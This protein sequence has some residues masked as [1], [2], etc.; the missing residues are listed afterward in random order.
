MPIA[1][2]CRIPPQPMLDNTNKI[3]RE[4]LKYKKDKKCWIKHKK[5]LCSQYACSPL[6]LESTSW[7]KVRNLQIDDQVSLKYNNDETFR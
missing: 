2:V 4:R 3:K 6:R 5:D 7:E 1:Q